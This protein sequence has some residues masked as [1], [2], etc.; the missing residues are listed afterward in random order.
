MQNYATFFARGVWGLAV[1][2]LSG[3]FGFRPTPLCE[4]IVSE[5]WERAKQLVNKGADPNAGH[6]CALA[7]AANRG[8]LQMVELL[9]DNGANPNRVASGNLAVIMGGSTPLLS[10]VQSRDSQVV[11][12]LLQKGASPREDFEAFS[13]VLN[14]GDVE[15]AGLLLDYGANPNMTLPPG[16]AVYADVR[17]S[18]SESRM[19][20][21]P[22]ED[23]APDRI[24]D[25]ARRF[26]CEIYDRS[27]GA[28]L[29][30]L[31]VISGVSDG[32]D[33]RAQIVKL[34]LDK[35][36]DPN[37]RTLNGTTP[38]MDASRWAWSEPNV[39]SALKSAGADVNATD[40]CGRTAA[41]YA[42]I[43]PY[44]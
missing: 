32:E 23:L 42:K 20:I 21:V 27:G 2:L 6:G 7:A 4:A 3:C 22:Q 31:A 36:A 41:D 12:L 34:L 24:R 14:Y 33:N 16:G 39:I 15:M 25:T 43:V 13:A 35:G 17:V 30:H 44:R 1:V 19:V 28:T 38:L 26:Q 8:Q 10:A 11:R 18:A 29:L 5:D 9:L 40:W 37:A